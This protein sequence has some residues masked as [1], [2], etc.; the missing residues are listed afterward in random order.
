MAKYCADR[1]KVAIDIG[2]TKIC[3]IVAH[4]ITPDQVEILGIGKAPSC[5]LLKG[6][7][8]DIAKTISSI[9]QAV[10]E[11]EL[12][13]GY[14]ITQAIIGVSGAHISSVNSH[15]IVPITHTTVR[16]EDIRQVL[17]AAQ[18]I[19]LP[20]GQQILHVLPQYFLLD[21][22]TKVHDPLGMH[23]IRLEVAI[24]LILGSIASVQNLVT[25]CEAA[26]VKVTDIILEQLASACAVLHDD[27]C[28]LGCALIDIGGGTSDVALYQ[29]RSI[30]HTMV[31]P[32]AGNHFTHDIASCL[33]L[34]LDTAEKL[35]RTY[36]YAC[37]GLIEHDQLI[38]VDMIHGTEKCMLH[39]RDLSDILQARAQELFALVH[40]EVISKKLESYVQAGIVLTGGGSLLAGMKEVAQE[41]FQRPVRI[42]Y[43]KSSYN[44]PATLASPHYATSYGLIVYMMKQEQISYK[45]TLQGPFLYRVFDRMKSWVGDFF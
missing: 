34:S 5:G 32:I 38:E 33:R 31:L 18:A 19:P 36:G 26:G 25:C 13:T 43:P 42:G 30:K 22:H 27:E 1:I 14:S 20:K 35:K 37:P 12:M 9:R 8:V 6:V 44:L 28:E 3:V 7:V 17:A 2:T 40:D 45:Q 11:A 21:G 4:A 24:H 10:Q 39:P 16:A 29:N 23:G 15:G 41:I